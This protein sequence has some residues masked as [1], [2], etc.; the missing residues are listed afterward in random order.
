MRTRNGI[1]ALVV[2]LATL[3]TGAASAATTA[4]AATGTA[5]G[6]AA[7]AAPYC[8]I[9]WGS[10]PKAGGALGSAP[11]LTTRTGRDQCWD[12]VVFEF[13]GSADGYAVQYGEVPTEG[14][15]LLLNPYLAGGAVLN[16]QLKAWSAY[17]RAG[18]HVANVLRYDTLRDVVY[19]GTSEGYSTFAIG[20]R[21]QLPYRVLVLAGPGTH[22]RIVIDIAHRW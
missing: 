15:G 10:L 8:G 16:M 9:T 18:D 12:R 13:N 19:G 11:L 20:V 1:I 7:T 14:E 22:S 2:G 6:S 17:G 4:A 21:A 5:A 3:L